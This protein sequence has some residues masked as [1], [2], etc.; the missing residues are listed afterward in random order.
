MEHFERKQGDPN[1][2]VVNLNTL[3]A[4]KFRRAKQY[5][6]DSVELP[7]D[8]DFDD[9]FEAAGGFVTVHYDPNDLIDRIELGRRGGSRLNKKT[10]R[11]KGRRR[12]SIRRKL[13]K[14]TSRRR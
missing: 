13:R 5:V 7:E 3:N 6:Q 11:S 12:H 14:L 8:Q 1:P 9:A 4:E 2:K 10:R